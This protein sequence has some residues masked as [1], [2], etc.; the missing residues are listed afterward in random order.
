M[1]YYQENTHT[2]D[3][4]L[5]LV[6]AAG[7]SRCDLVLLPE[8]FLRDEQG[9]ET[10]DRGEVEHMVAQLQ[11]LAAK[12]QM[13]VLAGIADWE[14]DQRYNAGI[15]IGRSG[16]RLGAYHKI[17]ATSWDMKD[18]ALPGN[19]LGVFDLDF[20]RI[21]VSICFDINWP[22]EW[23]QMRERGVEL[24][25]WLSAFDGGVPLQSYAWTHKYY[26]VSSVMGMSARFVDITG[27]ILA[28]TS[29]WSR[30]AMQD[31]NFDRLLCHIDGQWDKLPAIQAHYGDAVRIQGYTEE[32]IFTIEPT[33]DRLSVEQLVS[34]FDL[35]PYDAYIAR[36]TRAQG[37]ARKAG[38]ARS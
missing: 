21:G 25:C 32:D 5:V 24:V 20:A 31:I 3:R 12:H 29:K 1:N 36:S 6:E 22:D 30:L 15:L 14:G 28:T 23:R 10:V 37:E 7:A 9:K 35:E 27:H 18:G 26:I 33:D 2:G 11:A 34:E 13:Y 4:A 19:E 38:L 8:T 17:H 16:E